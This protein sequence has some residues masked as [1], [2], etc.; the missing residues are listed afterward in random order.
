MVEGMAS[1][2]D[3]LPATANQ[4]IDAIVDEA[5]RDH[6]PMRKTFLQKPASEGSSR[7]AVLAELVRAGDSLG[8]RLY[9]TALLKAS[10]A[11]WD[12]ALPAPVWARALG[13]PLPNTKGATGAI[14]KA[15]RR[16]DD[17]GLIRRGRYN[18]MA[19]IT[20]LREDGSGQ[21]YTHPGDKNRQGRADDYLKVPVALW[22]QGPG[23]EGRWIR[24]LSVPEL[25]MLLIS[26]SLGDGFWLPIENVPNWYGV[27]ADTAQRGLS[28]LR[29]RD[30]LSVDIRVKAAPLSATGATTEHRYTLNTPFGPLGRRQRSV[31]RGAN[32]R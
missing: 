9:L 28:G 15:W 10:S 31:R 2:S 5:A 22:L 6:A 21:D 12:T 23:G 1:A 14:S 32:R 26:L 30:L 25:A 4:T 24:E 29:D 7:G 3:E 17:H 27:S 20:L 19:Q 8:I 18:R 16:L 13:N 11:P